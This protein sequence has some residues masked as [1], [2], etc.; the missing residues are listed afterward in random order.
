MNKRRH[1]TSL[2][3]FRSWSRKKHAAFASMKKLIKI[4]TLSV[5]Y[6]IVAIPGKAQG[7]ND[8]SNSIQMKSYELEDVLVTAER[9]PVEAQQAARIVQVITKAEI[10]EIRGV[11]A[12]NAIRRLLELNLICITGRKDAFGKP[13][14]YGTTDEFLKYFNL[15]NIA[16]LPKINELKSEEFSENEVS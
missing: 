1:T 2:I 12:D 4:C 10:E 9:T 14:Q 8:S 15:K 5:A 13:L 3:H 16:D 7:Q 11:S 6:S